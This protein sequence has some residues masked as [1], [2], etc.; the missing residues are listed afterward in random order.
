MAERLRL[1]LDAELPG[2]EFNEDQLEWMAENWSESEDDVVEAWSGVILSLVELDDEA[3]RQACQRLCRRLKGG[4]DAAGGSAAPASKTVG[5]R[6]RDRK[7]EARAAEVVGLDDWLNGL[8][9]TQY[10]E[11]AR[12]WCAEMGY[13][14]VDALLQSDQAFL[15]TYASLSL[16][17]YIYIYIDIHI[18][19]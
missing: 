15:F 14:N 2:T 11:K 7:A 12:K 4:A 10:A 17:I 9:L 6:I 3:A 1:A 19:R 5:D 16:S 8:R 13:G 18:L